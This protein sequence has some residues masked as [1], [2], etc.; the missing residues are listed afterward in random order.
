MRVCEHQCDQCPFKPTSAPGW[1]GAYSPREVSQ[2][3]WRNVPFFCH[4]T[5]D[6]EDE[7]WMKKA[8]KD[9]KLCLGMLVYANRIL[10]PMRA[11][12]EG[13]HPEVVRLR[14]WVKANVKDSDV[15]VMKPNEFNEHH[16]EA[17]NNDPLYRGAR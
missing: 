10:A 11:N 2:S 16:K 17:I 5:I 3:A 13:A 15:Q 8:M 9:G 14:E 7:D 1:L 6:Y 4:P 12:E